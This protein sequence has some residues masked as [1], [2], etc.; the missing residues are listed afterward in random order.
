MVWDCPGFALVS[1]FIKDVDDGTE[2]LLIKLSGKAGSNETFECVKDKITFIGEH[3]K[4]EKWSKKYWIQ[5]WKDSL[6]FHSLRPE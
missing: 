5:F 1:V 2:S 4:L 6:S 3:K